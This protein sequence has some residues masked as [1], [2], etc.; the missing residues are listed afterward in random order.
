MEDTQ[1]TQTPRD[2]ANTAETMV[3][4]LPQRIISFLLCCSLSDQLEEGS[5]NCAADRAEEREYFER[6]LHFLNRE[7]KRDFSKA[8]GALDEPLEASLKLLSEVVSGVN[9]KIPEASDGLSP[10]LLFALK[11]ETE[12]KVAPAVSGFLSALFDSVVGYEKSSAKLAKDVDSSALLQIDV[13]SR[14][15]NFIAV[16]A[17][18]EA[19]RVGDV[20]RGFAVIAAEIKELSQQ[21]RVAVER[22]RNTIA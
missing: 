9:R 5:A 21:S 2:V 16:N 10:Q 6:A 13:I 22:M 8:A 15:I 14:K 19:A 11:G 12:G 20:G 17:S 4:A 3:V 18:V 7:F 1:E